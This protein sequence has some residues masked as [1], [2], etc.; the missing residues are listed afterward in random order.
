MAEVVAVLLAMFVHEAGHILT[1]RIFGIPCMAFRPNFLGA[2]MTFD[3]SRTT[4]LREA[5]V[6]LSGA[7]F[8]M[9]SAVLARVM[10][11]ERADYYLGV[12]A[13]LSCVNLLPVAGM[14]GGAVLRCVLSQFLLPDTVDRAVRA[15]S[16]CTVVL[17]WTAVLWVELR[18]TANFGLILFVIGLMIGLW[19]Q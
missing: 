1:A 3:F 17:L 4:Y 8:G 13:V 10:L 6:H 5:M 15:V 9:A 11:G 12:T 2:V 19:K 16:V 14:D 7:V 18:V